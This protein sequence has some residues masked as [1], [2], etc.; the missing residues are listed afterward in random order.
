MNA[1]EYLEQLS[2]R[3]ALLLRNCHLYILLYIYC[4]LCLH[5]GKG[6]FKV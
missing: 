5:L 3:C 2:A 1:V 4:F 6:F